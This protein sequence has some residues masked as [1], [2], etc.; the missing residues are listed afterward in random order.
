MK[1]A[2]SGIMLT[3]LLISEFMLAFNAQLVDAALSTYTYSVVKTNMLESGDDLIH[4]FVYYKGYLWA[5]TRTSPCRILRIN[6]ET[7]DYERII[8]DVGLDDGED[9][10]GAAGYIWVILYTSPSKIIR[11]DPE[12]L[13][14]EVAV[15]FQSDELSN[16]GSL[17][18]A[19]GYLWAGGGDGKIAKIDLSALTY[20][21]Y[22][23]PV[24]VGYTYTEALTSG[25]GYLWASCPHYSWL[26]G[27]Y[28]TTIVRINPSNPSDYA[29]VYISTLMCDD[30]AYVDGYLYTGDEESPSYVY[31]I[32]DNLTYSS[33]KA[34]DT[35]CYAIFAHD[36]S[37]WGAYVGSPGKIIEFDLNLNIKATYQLPVG[38]NNANEIAFDEAENIYVTCWESPA[39]IVKF[40]RA[41]QIWLF[42]SDFQYNIDDNYKTVE[43]TGH[44]R[45][46]ATLSAGTLFIEGQVTVSGPLPSAI[47]EVY[48]IATDGTN[49]EFAKQAVDLSRFSYWQTGTNTYN[50][51]GQ[52]PNVI[53]PINNGHYEASALITYN[54]AKYE[55]FINTAS[56]IDSHYLPLMTPSLKFM[57]VPAEGWQNKELFVPV[58]CR[59]VEDPG[60]IVLGIYNKRNMWYLVKVYK[61]MP[62]GTWLEIVPDEFLSEGPYVG[63]WSEKTFLYAPQVGDEIKIEV[64]NDKTDFGLMSLWTL[65]FVMRTLVGLRLPAKLPEY[66]DWN[67][68]KEHLKDFYN[69]VI[70]PIL[71]DIR[72]GLWKKVLKEV[73]QAVLEIRGAFSAIVVGLGFD[74]SLED[75]I[76]AKIGEMAGGLLRIFSIVVNVVSTR[77]WELFENL[78]KS[79]FS[80]DVTLMIAS[81]APAVPKVEVSSGLAIIQSEPYYVGETIN[82]RFRIT[83]KGSETMTLHVLTVGGRGP[84]GDVQDFTFKTN[85]VINP[86]E[87]YDYE[88]ELTLLNSGSYHFFV[89]YQTVDGVWVTNVPASAGAVNSLDINV[90]SPNSWVAA[91][92]CSPGELRIY[93]S[94]DRVTGLVNNEELRGIPHSFYFEGIVVIYDPN[95]SYKYQ[96]KGTNEGEYNITL[97]RCI[98]ENLTVFEA[99]QI[100]ISNNSLHQYTCNWDTLSLNAEGVIVQVDSEG[101]GFFEKTF[102]SGSKLTYKEFMFPAKA[103]FTFNAFWEGFNYPVIVSSSN[104]TI[105]DFNFYQS[106]KQISFKVSGETGTSGYCNVTIPKNLLKG[107]PWTV[108]LNGT[109][110]TFTPTQNET[111]S[112][113]YFTYT[114]SSTYEVTIQGTW[115]IPEFPSTL[116]LAIFM[117]TTLITTIIL[118][119]K[120]KR[121]YL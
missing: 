28:A 117:L 94:Q 36:N 5:S 35:L 54:I 116:I 111:H 95:D 75:K 13:A 63:P 3:L 87:A 59:S 42:D 1:K 68:F 21:I 19:F 107:E 85:I 60:K 24:V 96:V 103:T 105:A 31:K 26:Q 43:G 55:F 62:D 64:L 73:C 27:W 37:I 20:T 92:L 38:F 76:W 46:K 100:P 108:R 74:A 102:A 113:I 93:D 99:E 72:S 57:V 33:A 69:A 12:T 25:G 114:H 106:L 7:L 16:G 52:M 9:L 48:L 67:V 83:N 118:K 45:G 79:P 32:S 119:T 39:K 86:G 88:G 97:A 18:Y 6:P 82:A 78:F 98:F 66:T 61:K 4:G 23:Y 90:L 15:S 112:C 89:A 58:W 91:E 109:D 70:K 101:D 40:S 2:V 10:I 34:S 53:Q 115:V 14:W 104:S 44:L 71:S 121:Q 77:A 65:D 49:K 50:F 84:E 41:M 110:W 47:P 17:E 51:T 81:K 30:M 80:E 120:R 11:V 8:L 56:L 22:S 29:S